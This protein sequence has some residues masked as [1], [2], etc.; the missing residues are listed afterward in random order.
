MQFGK[1]VH[2]VP[3]SVRLHH[4]EEGST[5]AGIIEVFMDAAPTNRNW[6]RGIMGG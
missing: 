1:G 4:L 2:R 3:I 6:R 5:A